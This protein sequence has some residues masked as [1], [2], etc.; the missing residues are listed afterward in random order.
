GEAPRLHCQTFPGADLSVQ[1]IE[2]S[3]RLPGSDG[4]GRAWL[5][6]AACADG[7]AVV[8]ARRHP[9][10]RR[11]DLHPAWCL[12]ASGRAAVRILR[13]RHRSAVQKLLELSLQRRCLEPALL[14]LFEEFR[15]R[16][17]LLYI[18]TEA[19]MQP[20]REVFSLRPR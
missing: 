7:D 2:Q 6:P 17:R 18:A 13:D 8:G 5:D 10:N 4:P 15:A 12:S 14:G 16:R 1:R 9:R 11:A 3:L 20:L 19:K